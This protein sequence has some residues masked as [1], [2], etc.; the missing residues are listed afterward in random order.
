MASRPTI[1]EGW[2]DIADDNLSVISLESSSSSNQGSSLD[3]SPTP[4]PISNTPDVNE[5]VPNTD[6]K[7]LGDNKGKDKRAENYPDTERGEGSITD[8][9]SINKLQEHER[10]VSEGYDNV[11]ED[12]DPRF[13]KAILESINDI[14]DETICLEVPNAIYTADGKNP[15][16]ICRRI[17]GQ[18]RELA[19][20]LSGYA[21]AMASNDSSDD[22]PIDP[23]LHSWL[24]GVR[25]KALSL[26]ATARNSLEKLVYNL[27]PNQAFVG[28]VQDLEEYED[29]MDEFLPIMQVDF[30]EFQTKFMNLPIAPVPSTTHHPSRSEP[31]RIPS[32]GSSRP[33]SGSPL[34]SISQC[35]KLPILRQ[36]L[37]NL[38]DAISQAQSRLILVRGTRSEPWEVKGAACH[39][40]SKLYDINE[41]ISTILSNNGSEWIDSGISGGMSYAEFI[42][43][44]THYVIDLR[45]ELQDML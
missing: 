45:H 44:D 8:S 25:V 3:R 30:N 7:I 16:T 26:Q 41:A 24:S 19:P 36:E 17:R 22:I 15:F 9:S 32:P 12:V 13:L 6:I 28:I 4:T 35:S 29:K 5:R 2:E 43:L 23:G 40:A 42:A 18:L 1:S 31:I 14:L 33:L 20:I 11:N 27:E 10:E 39:L 34:G 38:K 21:K 37:Y